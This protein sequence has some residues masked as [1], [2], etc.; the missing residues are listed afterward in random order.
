MSIVNIKV[1]LN[2]D[3]SSIEENTKAL[4]IDNVIKYKEKDE[5]SV[6]LNL[7]NNTLIRENNELRLE[8]LF[9]KD[10]VTEGK[11]L[12]KEYNRPVLVNI[13]THSIK[14]DNKD[15]EFIFEV[16][17]KKFNYHIEVIE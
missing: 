12:I 15:I 9:E 13:K 14:N 10:K 4:L 3:D 7:D 11:I 5:T 1:S 16:E 2:T 17:D 6:I 8:Y